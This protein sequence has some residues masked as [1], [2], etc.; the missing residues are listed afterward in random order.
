MT[1]VRPGIRPGFD[2]Y[3][4]PADYVLVLRYL[5]AHVVARYI[6][7]QRWAEGKQN[8]FGVKIKR[9]IEIGLIARAPKMKR[10]NYSITYF[11]SKVLKAYDLYNEAMK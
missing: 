5:S 11:G 4:P 9:M 6:E 1:Q 10:G 3:F 8:D 2:I 7:L